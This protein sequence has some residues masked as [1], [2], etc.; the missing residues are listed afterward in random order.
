M[1]VFY[2]CGWNFFP[3]K[4]CLSVLIEFMLVL[5][6]QM[7]LFTINYQHSDHAKPKIN[8]PYSASGIYLE[9]NLATVPPLLLFS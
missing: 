5:E 6:R 2:I 1:P 4:V 3:H 8:Y 9:D 7:K